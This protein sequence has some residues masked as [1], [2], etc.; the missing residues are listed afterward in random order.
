MIHGHEPT[1]HYLGR[2]RA[3]QK[4]DAEIRRCLKRYAARR[5]FRIMENAAVACHPTGAARLRAC[6]ARNLRPLAAAL[7]TTSSSTSV[8]A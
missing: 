2:R 6:R 1:Q 3:G 8:T 7:I 5:L 4:T